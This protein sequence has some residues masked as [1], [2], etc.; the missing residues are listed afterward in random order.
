MIT[1]LPPPPLRSVVRQEQ[2]E[3]EENARKNGR[4][5]GENK[6]GRRC[7]ERGEKFVGEVWSGG[8]IQSFEE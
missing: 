4:G 3:A 8:N 5:E 2:R 1:E 7:R 6:I